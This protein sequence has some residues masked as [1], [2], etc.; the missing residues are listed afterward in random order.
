MKVANYL[1][2]RAW[3]SQSLIKRCFQGTALSKKTARPT[4][5]PLTLHLIFFDIQHFNRTLEPNKT[6]D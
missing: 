4:K 2:K 1:S 3:H 6:S 5:A